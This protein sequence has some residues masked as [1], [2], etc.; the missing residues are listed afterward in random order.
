MGNTTRNAEGQPLGYCRVCFRV[1][2]LSICEPW[3][4]DGVKRGLHERLPL[5]PVGTC[6]TC[7]RGEARPEGDDDSAQTSDIQDFSGGGTMRRFWNRI[8][9][10]RDV[11]RQLRRVR[12]A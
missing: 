2:W 8:T 5:V 6:R 7:E 3:E 1:R 4:G 12:N 9:F 11:R 10:R